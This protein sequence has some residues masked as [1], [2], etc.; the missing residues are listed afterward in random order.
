M[1]NYRQSKTY[2]YRE[3]ICTITDRANHTITDRTYTITDRTYVQLPAEQ[4]IQL[5]VEHMIQLPV[6]HVIQ[7][8][9]NINT[10]HYILMC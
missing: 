3:N 1:H 2:N 5:P 6:E 7:L 10:M 9:Y 8:N 4:I